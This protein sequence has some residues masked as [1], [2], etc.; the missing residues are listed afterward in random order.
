MVFPQGSVLGLETEFAE[1]AFRLARALERPLLPVAITGSHRVWEY[2]F[3]PRVRYGQ[4]VNVKVLPPVSAHEVGSRDPKDIR[5]LVQRRLKAA[6]L[7]EAVVPPRRF[8]PER[9]GYWDGFAY[10]IEPVFAK[11]HAEVA[12]H[13][14]R[15]RAA[16]T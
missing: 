15:L 10:R 1:G 3:S 14:A 9:D 6:A 4:R 5:Q 11:P 2:P 13:R 8:V 7:T 16:A 12:A